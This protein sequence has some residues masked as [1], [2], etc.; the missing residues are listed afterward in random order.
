MKTLIV[1]AL[2][3]AL[4]HPFSQAKPSRASSARTSVR[5]PN[6]QFASRER[7]RSSG[8]AQRGPVP[9]V[10]ARVEKNLAKI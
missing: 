9:D 6:R 1:F 7:H 5:W 10:A 4:A 8:R 2:L 3:G